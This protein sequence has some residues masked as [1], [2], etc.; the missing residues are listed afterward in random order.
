[1][2]EI[3]SIYIWTSEY[4]SEGHPD[5]IADQ[6]SDAVLDWYLQR[7]P[8][9]KV[10]C[11]VMVKDSDIYVSGE[12]KSTVDKDKRTLELSL[13]RL[14]R[15]LIKD[16]GYTKEE[17]PFFNSDY[18]RIHF[19]ISTQS[20]EINRAVDKGDIVTAGDQG[21]M[22]GYATRETPTYMPIAIYLA[23]KIIEVATDIRKEG[24]KLGHVQKLRPDMKSQVSV[25]YED[26]NAVGIH[27]VVFS[28]CHS[29]MISLEKV[30]QLFH[31]DILPKVLESIPKELAEL[32]TNKTV[33]HINPAGEWNIGG[34]VSD[35]GL[36]GRKIVVDQY[37]ADCE[38][39]GGAFSGKDPSK[40]DRSAAY[41]ARHIAITTL[42]ENK[43][44]NKI[45]VQLAY[46]IGEE[47]PVS[48]R[49][50]DPT[51]GKEYGLGKFTSEDLTPSKIIERLKL[52]TP[53][54]LQT[55][56]KGHFGNKDLE[57]EKIG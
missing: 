20:S 37:G 19:N 4:V 17:S 56:N 8:D 2:G 7:D 35:C 43:E 53:I 36:T 22:F 16:I 40:V 38:I 12:I 27:S 9:A 39:G 18:C 5:K 25:V 47:F 48:Y 11:E 54:Y 31:S 10:A 30:R 15:G 52:K 44:A 51:T 57:W 29:E 13:T 32:F 41:M 45:K 26:N 55:A 3:M 28:T 6:I 24:T 33:Y 46:A 23:K 1:M 34:P 21:I 50:F 49:I 14:I 42:H